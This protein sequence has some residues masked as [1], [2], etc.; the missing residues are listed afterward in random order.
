[1][2]DFSN[3]D[4]LPRPLIIA[5]RGSSLAAPENTI[6]AFERAIAEGADAIEFDVRRSG[7]GVLLVHHDPSIPGCADPISEMTFSAI[8]DTCRVRGFE[9]PTLKETVRCL[10]GRVALDVELKE[11]GYEAEVAA[12]VLELYDPAR[13]LFSSFDGASLTRLKTAPGGVITGQLLGKPRSLSILRRLSG[14]E[15]ADPAGAPRP[16]FNLP[17]WSLLRLGAMSRLKAAGPPVIAW[18]V[19]EPTLAGRLISTGALGIITNIPG[20]LR[21]ALDVHK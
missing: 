6:E 12:E 13:V 1:M 19:D 4:R 8:S 2:I 7:D 21:A 9:I 3:P 20:R 11:P 17:H 14:D 16:D 18:T 10:A 5:H 15:R